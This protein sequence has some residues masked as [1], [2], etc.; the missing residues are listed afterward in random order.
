MINWIIKGKYGRLM[1]GEKMNKKLISRRKFLE[2][3]GI[4]GAGTYLAAC[5]KKSSV[6]LPEPQSSSVIATPL[7]T[8]VIE[9][10][11]TPD[12]GQ[13]YLAVV[14]GE[15]IVEMTRRAVDAVGG[16]QRFVKNGNDVIIKPNICTDYYPYEYG[17]TTNPL[18]VATLVSL[19]F[20]AGAKRVRVMD[21]PFGGSA[22]SA[23][24]QSAIEEAVLGAGGEMEV[25]NKNKFRI[26]PIPDGRDIKEW[27]FYK[28][29]LDA[30]VV[31]DVPIAKHH[32]TTRLTLGC[33]NL[34][35]TILNRGLIHANIG[36]RIADLTSAVRPALTV[37]DAVRTLMRNGP[38]GGNLDDVRMT[39]TIIASH[40]I[41]AAD[42]YAATLFGLRG[43]D[44]S[45]I[46]AAADM[47][48]GS[49]NIKELKI[50]EFSL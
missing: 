37:V 35:G 30:D 29:I 12:V 17:A 47:G 41:V 28:D 15:D 31:I 44:I 36:Q 10:A 14:R 22:Q 48:L 42:S 11:K 7:P 19:A 46:R 25:M 26:M 5:G 18:V 34:M 23:Y 20:G 8:Q 16:M 50:E 49:M 32:G 45:Y 6:S 1:A 4:L 40:D 21:N 2:S 13:N 9:N 27:E 38:T 33:K 43:E 24:R 3:V 39:N